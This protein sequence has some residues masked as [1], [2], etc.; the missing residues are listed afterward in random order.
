MTLFS[1]EV[2]SSVVSKTCY[3]AGVCRGGTT[4]RCY[5]A[6][7]VVGSNAAYVAGVEVG[8]YEVKGYGVSIANSH[9]DLKTSN[10]ENL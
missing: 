6:G 7:M 3:V 8:G 10:P 1:G 9:S 2:I 5:N 4:R